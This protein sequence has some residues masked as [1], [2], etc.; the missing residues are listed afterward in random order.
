MS[1]SDN[2]NYSYYWINLSAVALGMG[3]IV[4]NVIGHGRI[5]GSEYELIIGFC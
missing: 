2:P 1:M 3:L 5:G 4:L